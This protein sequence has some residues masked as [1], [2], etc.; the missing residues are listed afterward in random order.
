[1]V[2][3][4]A[5]F[6]PES[7]KEGPFTLQEAL[8]AGIAES[9][10][11]RLPWRRLGKAM[12]CWAGAPLDPFQLLVAWNRALG[13]RAVFSGCS[14]AY[15]HGIRGVPNLPVEITAPQ[16]SPLRSCSGLVVRHCDLAAADL[17]TVGELHATTTF[18][19]LRD[20]CFKKSSADALSALDEALYRRLADRTGLL[21]YAGDSGRLPGASR[22]RR[23]AALAEPAESPMETLLRWTFI[24][25]GLTPPQVQVDLRDANGEFIGRA[26]MYYPEARLV[27]EFDGRNHQDRLVAD[28]RRQNL[29]LNAGFR[30]LRFTSADVLGR[31]KVVVNQ[32]KEALARGVASGYAGN[33]Q[34][35][36]A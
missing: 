13:D 24:E 6:V 17:V 35:D 11:R 27:I 28:M 22:M 15:L 31:P 7:L 34:N 10:L 30:L 12:Y 2:V 36:A 14:A 8:A 1:M 29:I 26:D 19:T 5:A 9:N 21:A 20:L 33:P 23:L 4:S 18:R 25:A 32:V 3:S 16:G